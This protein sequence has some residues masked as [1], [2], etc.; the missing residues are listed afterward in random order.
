MVYLTMLAYSGSADV[1]GPAPT[2]NKSTVKYYGESHGYV[3]ALDGGRIA[4]SNSEMVSPLTLSYAQAQTAFCAFAQRNRAPL[5]Q[6]DDGAR[7][8]RTR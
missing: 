1:S 2:P 5:R 7:A 4:S 8:S 3:N 6:P